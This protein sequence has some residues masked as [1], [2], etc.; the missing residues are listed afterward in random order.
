MM[1]LLYAQDFFLK[2]LVVK[3]AELSEDWKSGQR[4]AV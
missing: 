2:H 3:W 1:W 4:I